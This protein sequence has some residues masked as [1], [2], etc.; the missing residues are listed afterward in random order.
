MMLAAML[1]AALGG[2]RE[3][4]FN[5]F[6]GSCWVAQ[7]TQGMTDTHCFDRIL[8]GTHIRDTHHVVEGGRTVYEGETTYSVAG[9]R[10][11]FTYFNS[12]GGVG[13]GSASQ[14]EY[15]FRFTGSMRADPTKKPQRIDSEW[16]VI[17]NDHYDVRSLVPSASTGGNEVLHFTRKK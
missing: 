11:L 10:M 12:L 5:M 9:D 4:G 16:R 7:F 2:E 14:L 6:I 8:G 13:S 15:G 3:P 17:D 1:A